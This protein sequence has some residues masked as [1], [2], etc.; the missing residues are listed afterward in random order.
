MTILRVALVSLIGVAVALAGC[1]NRVPSFRLGAASK[2]PPPD[3][4]DLLREIS[5]EL[6]DMG[7][8]PIVDVARNDMSAVAASLGDDE[9]T[10]RGF[11]QKHQYVVAVDLLIE[12]TQN[13][14]LTPSLNYI[15]LYGDTST[16]FTKS[17]GGRLNQ[18]RHRTFSFTYTLK[19]FDPEEMGES[20]NQRKLQGNLELDGIVLAGLRHTLKE[21]PAYAGYGL[22]DTFDESK[23]G[24][25]SSA[26]APQFGSKM[27]FTVDYGLGN[28]GPS[29]TLK[30]FKGGSGSNG[31]FGLGRT[32]KNTIS[33][34]FAPGESGHQDKASQNKAIEAAARAAQDNN[35]R[36]LLQ[37]ILPR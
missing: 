35:T 15:H 36:M 12:V 16:N 23:T 21:Y 3:L 34:S 17:V 1:V 31:L 6:R 37:S 25:A 11:F 14:G 7:D 26:T 5:C 28:T 19:L 10:I 9:K 30:G 27:D 20:C 32:S 29:W 2:D 4:D 24:A 33:I 13:E 18:T 22:R 8:L